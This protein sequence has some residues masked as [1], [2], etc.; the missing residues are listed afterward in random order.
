MMYVTSVYEYEWWM[1]S[2]MIL[3]LTMRETIMM[4]DDASEQKRIQKR[5][6]TKTKN[7]KSEDE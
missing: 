2:W 5:W 3:T 1:R 4:D 6:K 7:K